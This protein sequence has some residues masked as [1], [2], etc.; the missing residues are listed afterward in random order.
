VIWFKPLTLLRPAV[1][2]TRL[3]AGFWSLFLIFWGE[4]HSVCF[5]SPVPGT[6]LLSDW[7]CWTLSARRH[8]YSVQTMDIGAL[9]STD[10]LVMLR[11]KGARCSIDDA[12]W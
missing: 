1:Y 11:Y 12:C 7:T 9:P 4:G 8:I 2:T 6:L 10:S 3:G 5:V